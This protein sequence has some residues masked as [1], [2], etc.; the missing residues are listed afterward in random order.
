MNKN[1]NVL[2]FGSIADI[3]GKKSFIMEEIDS[4]ER[5]QQTLEDKYPSL[6]TV[7]YAI[8]VNEEI[9]QTPVL[10]ENNSTVAILPPFSGG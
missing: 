1:I 2:A 7:Q 8:A 5:L 4:T 6:T 10:L 9:I 3:I